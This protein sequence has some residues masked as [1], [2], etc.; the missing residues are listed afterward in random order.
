MKFAHTYFTGVKDQTFLESCGVGD[1]ITTCYNGRNYRMAVEFVKTGKVTMALNGPAFL[2]APWWLTRHARHGL[3]DAPTQPF[4]TLERD[5]LHGQKLQGTLT[6]AEIH[7]FLKERNAL[8]EY[9][10]MRW[11][12]RA[13]RRG[14]HPT[15]ACPLDAIA[16]VPAADDGLPGRLRR[17]ARVRVYQ[18]HLSAYLIIVHR[19]SCTVALFVFLSCILA[20]TTTRPRLASTSMRARGRSTRR[21]IKRSLKFFGAKKCQRRRRRRRR[22]RRGAHDGAGGRRNAAPRRPRPPS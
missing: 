22:R 6:A 16:Q 2:H 15:A 19:A 5:L 1:L 4:E 12:G 14:S 20:G 9:A 11:R 18:A 13:V 3:V 17:P 21:G 10:D 8:A 7:D